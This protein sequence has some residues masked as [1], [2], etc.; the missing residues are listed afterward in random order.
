MR[1]PAPARARPMGVRGG[2]HVT[3]GIPRVLLLQSSE[4]ALLLLFLSELRRRGRGCRT[5]AI[6][7][8]EFFFDAR[9]TKRPPCAHSINRSCLSQKCAGPRQPRSASF[10]YPSRR[11]HR[12][13]P[14]SE[15]QPRLCDN[16]AV[17]VRA[18]AAARHATLAAVSD[19]ALFSSGSAHARRAGTIEVPEELNDHGVRDDGHA[20][21][22]RSAGPRGGGTL[23]TVARGLRWPDLL[24]TVAAASI[25]GV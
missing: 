9:R 3:R 10:L 7:E 8:E 12:Q 20:W 5:S 25:A 16:G 2:N 11:H 22:F 15:K 24:L 1:I 23:Q 6:P 13:H 14:P 19:S 17:D 18:V 21:T 4:C